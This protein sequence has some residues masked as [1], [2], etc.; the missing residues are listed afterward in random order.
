MRPW[1]RRL[2]LFVLPVLVVILG[3]RVWDYIE[4]RRLSR[5]IESIRAKGEPV[6]GNALI[7]PQY[8]QADN[9]E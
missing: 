1:I 6:N 7:D 3:I 9:A 8:G 2:G 4:A 5:E